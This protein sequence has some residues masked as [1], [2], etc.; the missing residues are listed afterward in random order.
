ML[1]VASIGFCIIALVATE[2]GLRLFDPGYLWRLFGEEGSTVYSETYGWDLRTGFRG[3]SF[4]TVQT[5]NR[6]GYRGRV[7]PTTRVPG[8]KRVLMIGDSIAF[9][10]GV[11]DNETFS[12][13]LEERDPDLEIVNLS[14]GGYGTDQELLKLEHE[15]LRYKPD[16]VILN[17]CLFSDFID[18]SLPSSLWDARQPKPFFI[19]DGH[20]LVLH[21]AH[22]RLTVLRR[23][24]Q[25][26]ADN[27][28]LYNRVRQLLDLREPPRERGVGRARGA[29]VRRH[30][31]A[32][33]E[34]TFRLIRRMDELVRE[35]GGRFLVV[36]HP[37]RDD[38]AHPTR[39]LRAFCKA[40][41][42][43]GIPIVDLGERYRAA[44]LTFEQLSLDGAGHLTRYGHQVAVEA[45]ETLIAKPVPPE[46]NYSSTCGANGAT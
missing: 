17:F 29:Q 1:S 30:F 21:D 46:W 37:D 44:G 34:L 8:M 28:H 26:L 25:W 13:L 18:N 6:L 42:L 16:L 41:L 23:T 39:F 27:S 9:G 5:I 14:V 31:E 19:W 11:R 43:E 24:T 45:F 36:I 38:Y 32:A 22:V 33:A 40:P 10:A 12:A 35:S 20:R 15:G 7:H 4:G 3:A 2:F